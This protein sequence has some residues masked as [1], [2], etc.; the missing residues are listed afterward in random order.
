MKKLITILLLLALVSCQSEKECNYPPAPYGPADGQSQ[1]PTTISYTY[2]CHNNKF[3]VV[4]YT[5][6]KECYYE[7]SYYFNTCRK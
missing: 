2:F 4:T 7:T 1:T 3:T 6:V 5:K